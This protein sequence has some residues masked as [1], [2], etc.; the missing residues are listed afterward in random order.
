[1]NREFFYIKNRSANQNGWS[2]K[3]IIFIP[4]YSIGWAKTLNLRADIMA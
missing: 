4:E 2:F 3:I 1:M